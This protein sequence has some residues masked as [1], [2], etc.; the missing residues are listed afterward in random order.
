MAPEA[1]LAVGRGWNSASLS[2]PQ[3]GTREHCKSSLRSPRRAPPA[4]LDLFI[5]KLR[6]PDQNLHYVWSN[7]SG[8][9]DAALWGQDLP[10]SVNA[11]PCLELPYPPSSTFSTPLHPR[12]LSLPRRQGSS[13]DAPAPAQ[14]WF[15]ASC[16]PLPFSAPQPVPTHQGSSLGGFLGVADG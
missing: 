1:G 3:P 8:C 5:N 14:P 16:L 2:M 9:S 12:T 13:G 11:I 7:V 15:L 4:V 10:F 6:W